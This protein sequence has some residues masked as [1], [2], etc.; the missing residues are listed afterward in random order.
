MTYIFNYFKPGAC[1]QR[2]IRLYDKP[3]VYR[4]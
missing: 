4:T 3:L 1:A 2:W